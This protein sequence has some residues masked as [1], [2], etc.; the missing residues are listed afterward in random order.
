VNLK[1]KAKQKRSS[2]RVSSIIETS[3]EIL[4]FEGIKNFNTNYIA[5]KCNIS[6]G[7]LYQYFQSKDLI[8]LEILNREYSNQ[9]K[10]MENVFSEVRS[11]KFENKLKV[12]IET[13]LNANKLNEYIQK[14]ESFFDLTKF[15]NKKMNFEEEF[16][17]KSKSFLLE[18]SQKI[19]P[20]KIEQALLVIYNSVKNATGD[21]EKLKDALYKLGSSF[22]IPQMN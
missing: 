17:K 1:K 4:D 16:I 5:K 14:S 2:N 19:S 7:S 12:V 20:E 15:K 11:G 9:L 18:S 8:M 3:K 21:E 22:L 10:K 13:S 6:I